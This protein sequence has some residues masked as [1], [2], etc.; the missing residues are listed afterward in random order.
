MCQNI[1][2]LNRFGNIFVFLADLQQKVLNVLGYDSV[3]NVYYGISINKKTY[4]RSKISPFL[5]WTGINNMIWY[6][7]KESPSLV[8]A[9]EVPFIPILPGHSDEPY[10]ALTMPSS[11][12]SLKRRRR[13]VTSVD[14]WGCNYLTYLCSCSM[15][16]RSL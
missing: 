11:G 1:P 16:L 8:T 6:Q 14:M 3:D 7:I 4:I 10:D 2:E 12:T 13:S 9:T 5:I 15:F